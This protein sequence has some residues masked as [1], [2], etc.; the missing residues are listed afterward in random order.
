M[1]PMMWQQTRKHTTVYPIVAKKEMNRTESV[2]T[3]STKPVSI[4]H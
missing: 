4:A 1:M 3:E 2:K